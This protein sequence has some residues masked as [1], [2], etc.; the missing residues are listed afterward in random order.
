MAMKSFGTVLP[1]RR[2]GDSVFVRLSKLDGASQIPKR[3]LEVRLL[4]DAGEIQ[5][6]GSEKGTVKIDL[7]TASRGEKPQS[8]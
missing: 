8:P 2:E 3:R 7:S 1:T 6:A 4:T 5:A